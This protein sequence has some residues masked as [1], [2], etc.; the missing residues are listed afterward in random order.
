M[1]SKK[2]T[3]EKPGAAAAED[4]EGSAEHGKA[5][6]ARKAPTKRG[7]QKAALDEAP[8]AT[9]KVATKSK[10]KAPAVVEG[11]TVAHGN[12]SIASFMVRKPK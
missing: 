9:G 4:S 10:V 12:K 5:K 7:E 3:Q 2:N 8:K 11:P 6:K 1:V